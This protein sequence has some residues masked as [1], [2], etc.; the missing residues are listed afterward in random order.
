MEPCYR[1]PCDLITHSIAISNKIRVVE[2]KKI[3]QWSW[4]RVDLICYSNDSKLWY[5]T[6][7]IS[8]RSKHF[9]HTDWQFRM[10]SSD[11]PVNIRGWIVLLM[12][13]RTRIS[14]NLATLVSNQVPHPSESCVALW[15]DVTGDRGLRPRVWPLQ[16]PYIWKESGQLVLRHVT[17]YRLPKLYAISSRIGPANRSNVAI[18][19]RV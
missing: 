2:K 4:I 1:H 18:D 8:H 6:G 17:R 9:I 10:P 11:V 12:A 15:T 13:I 5:F 7:S 3:W 16:Y 14:R 19:K